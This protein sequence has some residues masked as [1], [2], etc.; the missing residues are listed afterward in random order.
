M[1]SVSDYFKDV[2]VLKNE[3]QYVLDNNIIHGGEYQFN[4][5]IKQMMAKGM[6]F[7]PGEVDGRTGFVGTKG[8]HASKP[9]ARMLEVSHI[10]MGSIWLITDVVLDNSATIVPPCYIGKNVDLS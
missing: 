8:C 2:A 7:V 4:D 3:L 9:I 10:M 6:K 5:G 1:R